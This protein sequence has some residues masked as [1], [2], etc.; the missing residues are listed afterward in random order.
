[1]VINI[2]SI[3]KLIH[4]ILKM[5]TFWGFGDSKIL[6][7]STKLPKKTQKSSKCQPRILKMSTTSSKCQPYSFGNNIII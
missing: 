7:M 6:K 1:M 4:V 3:K 5:S 2:Y